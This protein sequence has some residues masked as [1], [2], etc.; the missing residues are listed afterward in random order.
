[1]ALTPEQ[2]KQLEEMFKQKLQEQYIRG[3]KVGSKS[4]SKVIL[5]KL[6]D[7][8]KS[9]MERIEDVKRFCKTTGKTVET[10]KN[11]EK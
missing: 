5:D 6:N 7:S 2:E 9:L 1:M 4:V 8:S 10:S 11:S 3:L